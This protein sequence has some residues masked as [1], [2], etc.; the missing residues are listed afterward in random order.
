MFNTIIKNDC[1]VAGLQRLAMIIN[2]NYIR[3]KKYIYNIE[4]ISNISLN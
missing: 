3:I 4:Q 1:L 2:Y